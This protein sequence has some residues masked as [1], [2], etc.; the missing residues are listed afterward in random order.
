MEISWFLF[1]V[2]CTTQLVTGFDLGP[3]VRI[4]QCRSQCLRKH[5]S[6]GICDWYSEQQQQT[7]CSMVSQILIYSR[8]HETSRFTRYDSVFELQYAYIFLKTFHS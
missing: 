8:R 2:W 1:F 6:D 7:T 3:V 5:T 4:A